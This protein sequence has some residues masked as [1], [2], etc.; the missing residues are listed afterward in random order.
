MAGLITILATVAFL[1]VVYPAAAQDGVRDLVVKIHTTRRS[2][3]LLKP[4]TKLTPSQVSGSGVVIEGKRILT[5]AHVVQYASTI[6]VQP[7]QSSD[8]LTARVAAIAPTVDLALLSLEDESFFD[9]RGSL[10]FAGELPRVKDSVS[11]YGYPRGGAELSVTEGIV[12]RIEFADYYY[13]GAGLRIQV[14]AP[15]NPGNSG[16][17]A[18]S[19][20]KLVGLVFSGIPNAQNIGY[21]IPVEEVR[22]FLDDVA[23]GRY[24]GKPQIHDQLQTVEN[25]ALRSRLGLPKG[26]GGL[27]VME[28]NKNGGD[29]PL[30][31]WDVITHI[32]DQKID[33]EGKVAVRYDLRLSARYLVQKHAKN[34]IVDV[35]IYRDGQPKQIQLPVQSR[36][37]LVL[38]YLQNQ[39]P[40]YFIYGPLVFSQATQDYLD[41]LGNQWESSLAKRGSLLMLRRYDK[42]SFDGEEL[43]VVS[44]PMFPHRITKGYDDPNA[45]VVTEVNDVPVKSL[46]HLVEVLRAAKESQVVFKFGR[47]SRRTQE[48]LV[49]DRA[50]MMKATEEVLND[51]GI[52]YQYSDDIR[53]I[54]ESGPSEKL[55]TGR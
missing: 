26:I 31:E 21:L 29:Y 25:D 43:V 50:E 3:D 4:W 16:G 46:R 34:G 44:A 17:P 53:P 47:S 5:N 7:N 8:R 19:G 23:D 32:G 33:S 20:G 27:M 24:D 13:F 54:W 22:S 52:R 1:G 10:P 38:P 49:F 6:Y 36:R 48:T 35:M 12:S 15:L 41:R 11:V 45:A 55:A 51:N 40:R 14:D 2:P 39:D 18:V 9:H 28:P 42:P 37:D 30:Q